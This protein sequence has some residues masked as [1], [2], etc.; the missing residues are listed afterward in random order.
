SC[1]LAVGMRIDSDAELRFKYPFSFRVQKSDPPRSFVPRP[2]QAVLEVAD[3]F[4][5]RR[6][7]HFA[8]CANKTEVIAVVERRKFFGEM[9]D[10]VN[11]S[12]LDEGFIAMGI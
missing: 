3:S 7:G 9:P 12:A 10:Q 5:N 4:I 8:I 6:Y 11:V 1:P 2:R